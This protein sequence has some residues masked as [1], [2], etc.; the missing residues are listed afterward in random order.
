MESIARLMAELPD[1]YEEDCYEQGAITRMRGVSCPADLMMLSMFHLQNGCTLLEISEVAR[2]TRLGKMSDVAFMKRFEK[3][4]S[5]FRTINS[6]IV[7]QGLIDYK[8]PTWLEGKTVIA[9]DASDVTE[10]GRS[11]RTYRLHYALDIFKMGSVDQLITDT[12]VGENLL[13]FNLRPGYLVIADRAYSTING[14]EYCKKNGAEF[15]LRLRKNSFTVRDEQGDPIDL[16]EAIKSIGSENYAD[17]HAFATNLHGNKVPIRICAKKKEPEAIIRTQKKLKRKE[18][19]KQ[20]K[21]SDEAKVFNEY[22]VVVTNLNDKITA[23]EILEAYRLRWQVE[24]YFKR[25]KSILDF[26]ELPKRRLD[27]VIA[28]LNGKLMIA[29]LIEILLSKTSFSPQKDS[30]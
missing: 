11:G 2:I 16:I 10:K 19:K 8:K 13:N 29:L 7:T 15:I 9:V 17:I 1:G 27:S 22:I 23:E 12:K 4:G 6:K 5:W 21:I 26:G 25:L 18:S 20:L 3:C 28:W 24:I 14:I 30:G